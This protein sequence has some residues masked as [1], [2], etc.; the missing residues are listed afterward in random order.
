MGTNRWA[1][2]LAAA[3]LSADLASALVLHTGDNSSMGSDPLPRGSRG[4]EPWP[5]FP[6]GQVPGKQI[7]SVTAESYGPADSTNLI[8]KFCAPGGKPAGHYYHNTAVPT[9]VPYLVERSDPKFVDAALVVAPGGGHDHLAF[10]VT[11]IDVAKWLNTLGISVF[12][13]KY[14]VPSAAWAEG[15]ATAEMDGQ[16]ALSLVRS[17][18]RELGIS[19]SRVGLM[20]SSA[21]GDLAL[22]L[23]TAAKRAYPRVDEIDD[24]SFRPDF[25]LLLYPEVKPTSL[26]GAARAPSSFIA[27]AAD[28][29]CVKVPNVMAFYQAMKKNGAPASE[30]HIYP[31]GKHG[32][33]TCNLYPAMRSHK[34]CEWTERAEAYLAAK[35]RPSSAAALAGAAS[36]P[37]WCPP[38]TCARASQCVGHCDVACWS[39][40]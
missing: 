2:C 27:M 6:S 25:M 40:C 4:E 28:D 3:L 19:P 20:G 35:F 33:G 37:G 14:R 30:I 15:A 31:D 12:V 18:A 5:L 29:P 16:R 24:V 26:S 13:L 1:A 9:L 7:S 38:R 22:R 10:D 39:A 32:Y 11:G 17:R 36:S 23:A 8:A 21:G 34:V